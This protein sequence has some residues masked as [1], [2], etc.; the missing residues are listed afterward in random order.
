MPSFTQSDRDKFIGTWRLLS[1]QDPNPTADK[2]DKDPVGYIMYDSTGH[3]A[4]QIMWRPDRPKFKAGSQAQG[5]PEEIRAAFIGWGAYF[6]TYE[7]NEQEG[8]VIQCPWL[9]W[10]QRHESPAGRLLPHPP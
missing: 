1:I 2:P 3:M 8:I 5:T 10:R 6:G 9:M 7:V 4:V